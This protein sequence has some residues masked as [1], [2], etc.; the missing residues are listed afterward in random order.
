MFN[1][2]ESVDFIYGPARNAFL[3]YESLLDQVR[4]YDKNEYMILPVLGPTA[5]VMAFDLAKEGYQAID[6]GQMPGQFRKIK[7]K[8]FGDP[9]YSI[10]ELGVKN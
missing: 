1:N 10:S 6:F 4:Q 9:D 7:G 8:L 2:A 5:T 3:E